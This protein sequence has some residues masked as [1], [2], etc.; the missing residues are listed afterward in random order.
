M[1]LMETYAVNNLGLLLHD[2]ARVVRKRFELRSR[3]LELPPAQWR[4]LIRLMREG[5]ASQVRLAELLEI[6]P[7]SVSRLVDRMAEGGWVTRERDTADRRVNIVAPTAKARD[8]YEVLRG[9]TDSIY[10]EALEGIP[11]A[12]RAILHASLATIIA[13]LSAPDQSQN[14]PLIICEAAAP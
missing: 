9:M 3:D 8:A 11:P 7:I 14:S 1:M 4:L 5:K 10:A 12:E 2:A 13:N 6:E